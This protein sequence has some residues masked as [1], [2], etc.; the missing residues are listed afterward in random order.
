MTAPAH[1]MSPRDHPVRRDRPARARPEAA[2]A[3][4][5]IY[6][7]LGGATAVRC[8]SDR[9]CELMDELPEAAGLRRLYPDRLTD[10]ADSLFEFLSGWL[11]GPAL[12]SARQPASPGPVAAAECHQWLLCMR[13]ALAEQVDDAGLR[14]AL[15]QAL[16]GMAAALIG[17]SIQTSN[18]EEPRP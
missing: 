14:A 10:C 13:L 2:P 17:A 18:H 3:S 1:S 7:L 5:N 11:G 15:L 12:C 6:T 9:F 16:G 4:S 8:L